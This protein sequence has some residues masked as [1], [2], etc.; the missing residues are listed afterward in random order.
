[1][2][3]AELI[4]EASTIVEG[5]VVDIAVVSCTILEGLYDDLNTAI[6]K[7]LSE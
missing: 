6:Q 7:D 5:V 2:T 4:Q 3:D 1:M